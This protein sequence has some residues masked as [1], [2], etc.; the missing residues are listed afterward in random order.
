[1]QG[2]ARQLVAIGGCVFATAEGRRPVGGSP[3]IDGARLA[4]AR[5]RQCAVGG[6]GRAGHGWV[7]CVTRGTTW[8]PKQRSTGWH[9]PGRR[10]AEGGGWPQFARRQIEI[11]GDGGGQPKLPEEAGEA[12]P[13]ERHRSNF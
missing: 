8:P 5:S 7:V 9:G 6:I 12:W 2:E 1:M 3:L 11:H 4:V 10:P 13:G